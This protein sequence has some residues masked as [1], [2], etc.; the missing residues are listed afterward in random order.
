MSLFFLF[1]FLHTGGS[2]FFSFKK[3]WLWS[4]WNSCLYRKNDFSWKEWPFPVISQKGFSWRLPSHPIFLGTRNALSAL[5]SSPRMLN[6]HAQALWFLKIEPSLPV[7]PGR[8]AVKL[9][10]NSTLYLRVC[11][12]GDRQCFL[13]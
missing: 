5:P 8:P 12:G 7:Y 6:S 9:H 4:L 3:C 10:Y 2:L 1:V 13:V 11:Q